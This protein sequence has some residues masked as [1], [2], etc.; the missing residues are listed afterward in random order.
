MFKT[1]QTSIFM[2][3]LI[4]FYVQLKFV[5][6]LMIN[7]RVVMVTKWLLSR[8]YKNYCQVFPVKLA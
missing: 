8:Q 3:N 1:I 5:F 6:A 7:L 4:L 2:S